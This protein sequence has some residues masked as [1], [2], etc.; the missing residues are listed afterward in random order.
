MFISERERERQREAKHVYE[1]V[2]TSTVPPLRKHFDVGAIDL[3]LPNQRGD[4]V[5]PPL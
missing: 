1:R 4:V 5:R 3:N 2:F